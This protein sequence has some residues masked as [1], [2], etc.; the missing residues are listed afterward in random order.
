MLTTQLYITGLGLRKPSTEFWEPIGQ[1]TS[2][3]N[4]EDKINLLGYIV[5][6][7]GSNDKAQEQALQDFA[8]GLKPTMAIVRSKCP[9]LQEPDVQLIATEFLA[10]EILKPESKT[11]REEFA[12]W[13]NAMTEEEIKEPLVKRRAIQEKST[14]EMKAFKAERQKAQEELE[15]QRKRYEEVVKIARDN[16]SMVLNARTGKFEEY[17]P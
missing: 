6:C 14:N 11:T 12:K 1:F 13:L 17:K 3:M 4:V 8:S 10:A 5:P 9:G 15:K 7:F 2:Q 16:R